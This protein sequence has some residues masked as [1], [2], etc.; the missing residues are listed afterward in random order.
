MAAYSGIVGTT[1]FY[2]TANGFVPA[3]ITATYSGAAGSEVQN[4]ALALGSVTAADLLLQGYASTRLT[5]VRKDTNI[6]TVTTSGTVNA[7]AVSESIATGK[8]FTLDS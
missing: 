4:D 5:A 3:V 1:V 8:W 7:N 6:A 2:K